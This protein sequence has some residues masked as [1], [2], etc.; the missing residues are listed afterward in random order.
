MTY[1][2]TSGKTTRAKCGNCGR[3]LGTNVEGDVTC[4][5]CRLTFDVT[6]WYDPEK[7]EPP[8]NGDEIRALFSGGYIDT[9]FAAPGGWKSTFRGTI[10]YPAQ[11][12]RRWREPIESFGELPVHFK[13]VGRAK[14]SCLVGGLVT[15]Q[16]EDVTCGECLR[17][18]QP[19]P[20]EVGHEVDQLFEHWAKA[21]PETIE[22]VSK[23]IGEHGRL[24]ASLGDNPDPAVVISEG[25]KLLKMLTD[26]YVMPDVFKV[27]EG[28]ERPDMVNHPPHYTFGKFEVI[29]V[30]EDW[31][32]GFSL[33]NA[34]KYIAR[35]GRK[36]PERTLEDL[37]KAR[38]YLEREIARLEQP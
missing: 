9:V 32:L 22:K 7:K 4:A 26:W 33:G 23:V 19:T 13:V 34:V 10:E 17:R 14:T 16:R 8:R 37:Q 2:R 27:D 20:S 24:V 36:D 6:H 28:E 3:P 5:A 29:D 25:A 31:G 12:L 21:D 1:Y 30:I 11:D 35:A 18:L 15:D 38:W